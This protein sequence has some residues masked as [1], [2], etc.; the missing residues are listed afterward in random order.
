MPPST[1]LILVEGVPGSGKTTTAQFVRN[2]LARR[3]FRPRLYLEGDLDHPADYKSVACLTLAEFTRLLEKYPAQAGLLKPHTVFLRGE[4]FI[5]YRKLANQ[6]SDQLPAGLID[7]L[8]GCEIYD[9]PV[10]KHRR[11]AAERWQDFTTWALAGNSTFIFECCFLQNPLTV[12]LAKHN[13]S[14][15]EA[16]AHIQRLVEITRPLE[17]LLI[18]LDPPDLRATL[19][20]AAR[21]RPPQWLD[22]VTAYITG[23]AWGK[24]NRRSGETG[25]DGL[26]RFYSLRRD[27]EQ[28]LFARRLPWR[29]LWVN[30]P[31]STGPAPPPG[32]PGF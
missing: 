12:L 30:T 19:E 32:W 5:P 21:T 6:Y 16:A 4:Y 15:G 17:P 24:T 22:Y 28:D 23:Q 25:F 14:A 11:V 8:A 26:L 31:A 9:L 1:R 2:W 29:K 3:A 27:L 13:L 18:Y 20:N 7:E 10:E